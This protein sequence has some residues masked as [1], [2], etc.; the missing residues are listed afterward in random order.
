MFKVKVNSTMILNNVRKISYI[1][2]YHETDRLIKKHIKRE[3]NA[4]YV[5]LW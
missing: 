5:K 4:Y 1:I 2:T 3:I